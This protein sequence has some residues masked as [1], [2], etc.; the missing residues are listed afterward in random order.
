MLDIC[1]LSVSYA[2]KQVLDK[3]RLS[4]APGTLCVITGA[5]GS[6]KSTLLSAISGV[7]PEHIHANVQ[8]KIS[9]DATDLTTIPLREKYRYLWHAFANP[10]TQLFFPTCE[11]ELAFALEN[12]G[13]PQTQIR[14]RVNSAAAFFGL[15]HELQ[16]SPLSLS[17]GQKKLLLC[18]IA[19]AISPRLYLLDE[20]A[21]GLSASSVELLCKWL[22][23]LKQQGSIVL[24]AEHN[25]TIIA[26]ADSVIDLRHPHD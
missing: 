21:A 23:S 13:I 16:N 22:S 26:L 9:L 15:E 18:A 20:P 8:G 4:V 19:M 12:M 24:A 7:V 5:N 14:Q 11:A 6:G 1:K 17:G 10:D 3:F 2:T 25:P